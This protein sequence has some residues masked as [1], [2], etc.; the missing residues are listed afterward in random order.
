MGRQPPHRVG[1]AEDAL[2]GV[3]DPLGGVAVGAGDR[4]HRRP[5]GPLQR[6]RFLDPIG[7]RLEGDRSV[8]QDFRDEKVDQAVGL[9]DRQVDGACL[10]LGFGTDVPQLPGR[11]ALFE[12]RH[13][14]V[15]GLADPSS[16]DNAGGICCR[17]ERGVDHGGD[18]VAAAEDRSSFIEPGGTLF[19]V[20]AR[21]VFGVA[22]LQRGL[23]GQL[24]GFDRGWRPAMIVLK[25]DG[26]CAPSGVEARRLD[27]RSFNR[28]STPT[29]SRMGRFAGSVPG[30]SANRTTRLLRR[31]CSRAVL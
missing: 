10:A 6:V 25:L 17:R 15:S 4:V 13:D 9:V 18:G 3:E 20:R 21:F 1:R 8:L 2:F 12:H 16:I 27:Q 11:A 30:R 31:C 24:E 5:V 22:G 28:G 7:R 26:E 19:G 29:I 14:P 23:L